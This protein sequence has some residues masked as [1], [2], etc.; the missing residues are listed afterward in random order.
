MR[1]PL[2]AC[3]L[4]WSNT[5]RKRELTNATVRSFSGFFSSTF[6]GNI[7]VVNHGWR[8]TKAPGDPFCRCLR[9]TRT[10][11][12]KRDGEAWSGFK[13]SLSSVYYG[14]YLRVLHTACLSLV[15]YISLCRSW[16]NFAEFRPAKRFFYKDFNLAENKY[17]WNLLMFA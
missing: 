14:T 16:I 11:L 1:R 12:M 7:T 15:D 10:Q 4:R 2:V 3:A 8:R 17:I 9:S 5:L 13:L 6:H